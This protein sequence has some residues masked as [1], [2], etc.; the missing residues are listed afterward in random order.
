MKQL[1]LIK[2]SKMY[3][4]EG[5]KTVVIPSEIE[6]LAHELSKQ[7]YTLYV[8]GGYVRDCLIGLNPKDMDICGNIPLENIE[9][10]ATSLGFSCTIIQKE[11]GTMQLKKGTTEVEYTRFRKEVYDKGHSPSSVEWVDNLS[12]D[13][14]RR[15]FSINAI[16]Y[17]I[18]HKTIIDPCNGQQDIIEKTIRTVDHP[19]ITLSR[20]GL[21]I[22]RALRFAQELHFTINKSTEKA[23]KENVHLLR[24]I[25]IERITN[26]LRKI[27]HAYSKNGQNI[28]PIE[29]VHT[30]N[31][32]RIWKEIVP[33]LSFD[34]ICECYQPLCF[35]DKGRNK[36]VS[37]FYRHV[38]RNIPQELGYLGLLVMLVMSDIGE[39]L[40]E[41]AIKYS[42]L[43][44]LGND[45]LKETRQIGQSVERLL[46]CMLR[47]T[48]FETALSYKQ[49]AI[50]YHDFKKEEKQLL[51][52]IDDVYYTKLEA[53]YLDMKLK[54]I[55]L[56]PSKLNV[57]PKQLEELGY[58]GEM[59][60]RMITI[61]W[62]E[63][64][65]ENIKNE[66][67]ALLNY[68]VNSKK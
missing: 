50:A 1:F 2:L 48:S 62:S 17:D 3:K 44:V 29:I 11:L 46:N 30:L 14:M 65:L 13:A 63:V 9:K 7:N 16:Y 34:C 51:H 64:L 42:V 58:K 47:Q 23:C 26:E 10:M 33:T 55:P 4:K 6:T 54:N 20:D 53:E 22:L 38:Y 31:S 5:G 40:T 35:W 49:F 61:L 57:T 36:R 67:Q 32:W 43:K 60:G 24:E 15:D 68:L 66:E 21:R 59:L 27:F 52:L 39:M 25:S 28:S 56:S 19:K 45:G 37:R 8:V 18:I 41:G 12:Q